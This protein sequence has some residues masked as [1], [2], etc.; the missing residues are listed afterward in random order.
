M[1]RS[2]LPRRP[3][4]SVPRQEHRRQC[5]RSVLDRSEDRGSRCPHINRASS[6]GELLVW[7]L[8]VVAMALGLTGGA[9]AT[10]GWPLARR[11]GQLGRLLRPRSAGRIAQPLSGC[12]EVDGHRTRTNDAAGSRTAEPAMCAMRNSGLGRR[13][14]AQSAGSAAAARCRNRARSI[15]SRSAGRS[16]RRSINCW[17]LRSR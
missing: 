6:I 17:T 1:L 14:T 4:G 12:S 16:S 5:H 10:R 15:W 8:L 7:R 13:R 11:G 3:S 2:A 9:V